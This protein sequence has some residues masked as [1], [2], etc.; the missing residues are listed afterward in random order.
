MSRTGR[1]T[2]PKR[3]RPALCC[4]IGNFLHFASRTNGSCG[5]KELRPLDTVAGFFL[6][7]DGQPLL[8]SAG[9]FKA[10]F[11]ISLADAVM[12]AIAGGQS[13]DVLINKL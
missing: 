11:G 6:V 1:N 5:I 9:R 7:A 13:G 2:S 4:P 12:A 3:V 10:R 8:L